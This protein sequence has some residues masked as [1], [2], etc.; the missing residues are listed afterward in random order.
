M[1]TTNEFSNYYSPKQECKKGNLMISQVNRKYTKAK[2]DDVLLIERRI[3]N[4]V[5]ILDLTYTI[6]NILWIQLSHPFH[7]KNQDIEDLLDQ[8]P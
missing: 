3:S 2:L 7:T 1:Q 4:T 5:E 8:G 6:P